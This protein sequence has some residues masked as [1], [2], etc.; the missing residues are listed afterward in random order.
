MNNPNINIITDFINSELSNE[1]MLLDLISMVKNVNVIVCEY[2]C[3][4]YIV[5]L[6]R[7]I[8]S[9]TIIDSVSE[10]Y[11][12]PDENTRTEMSIQAFLS[13]LSDQL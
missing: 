11:C 9:V 3:N 6:E 7:K 10:E 1:A 13:I 12:T 2:E 4:Q 5:I 8:D